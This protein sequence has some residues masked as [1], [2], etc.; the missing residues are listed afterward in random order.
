MPPP[1]PRTCRSS[2]R[3]CT[4]SWISRRCR[5][6]LLRRSSPSSSWRSTSSP[7]AGRCVPSAGILRAVKLP[8]IAAGLVAAFAL[9]LVLG[10]PYWQEN[11]DAFMAMVAHGY[12]VNAA[13]SIALLFSSVLYG[14]LI[15]SVGASIAGAQTYGV[16]SY[17]LLAAA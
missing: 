9:P 15:Q 13:P 5:W 6:P 4:S 3:A 2:W 12:G 1:P 8:W 16:L 17:V 10:Q 11:D 14:T 7:C